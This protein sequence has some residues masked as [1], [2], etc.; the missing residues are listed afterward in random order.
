KKYRRIY[1]MENFGIFIVIIVVILFILSS[2]FCY[3]MIMGGSSKTW[4]Q[5][6]QP[7]VIM[8]WFY[9]DG[10]GFCDRMQP[11]WDD[12]VQNLPDGIAAEKIDAA[13]YRE[14]AADF[15]VESV[16]HIVKV[17]SDKR[18]IYSGDRSAEDFSKFAMEQI[19]V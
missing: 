9:R 6:N 7:K 19:P 1:K 12:F 4:S 10:C 17:V 18:I 2:N 11:A 16:P 13:R 14:M 15:R 3:N 8:L 5:T